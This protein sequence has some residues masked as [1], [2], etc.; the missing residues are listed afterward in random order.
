LATVH[1]KGPRVPAALLLA[2]DIAA[3]GGD[4]TGA[5]SQLDT[6]IARYPDS[7][8][9]D[10]A[11]LNR[12]ILAIRAGRGTSVLGELTGL[13]R[14]APLSPY[15]GRMRLAHGVILSTSSQAPEA[16][17]DFKTA[18]MQGEGAV[19]NLGLGRIAFERSQWDAAEREF[20][21]ARDT[22]TGAVAVAAEYGIAAILWNQGK[23][24]EFK[25]FAQTLLAKP[26]DPTM[27]PALLAASASLAAEEGRWKDAQALST[28]VATEFPKSDAAPA[29]LADVGTAAAR[30][31][32]WPLANETFKTLVDKYPSYKKSTDT[33]LDYAEAL[34]RTGAYAEAKTKLTEFIDASP[35]DPELPRALL[36]L[37]R[38][39]EALGDGAGAAEQYKRVERD[40]PAQ[41][42]AAQL[43]SARVLLLAGNWD[44]ARPI[45]E[46][47]M[48]NGDPD[49]ASEAAFRLGE[50]H[51]AAGR[52]LPAVEAYMTAV[53][54]APD[55]PMARRAL[56]GAGQSF[57]ALKQNDSAVIV[58]KKL[59]ASKSVEPELADAAKKNL[60]ALGVN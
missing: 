26:A 2:A 24:D 42:M 48:A 50:G 37:G 15:M 23:T 13:I 17:R 7:E 40:F 54:I 32:E 30:A 59:L 51:R 19:A 20:V 6:L 53:Y 49:L 33:R 3:R 4:L 52:H 47:V 56:L 14:N 16:E 28:R 18:L 38:T 60:K 43:G 45:L 55:L 44:E 34:V 10:L 12:A 31:N 41:Q 35:R 21:E 46:R 27:T 9:A 36:L 1:P 11:R 8:Y 29:A 58:Y 25:P 39:Q 5:K 57:R 22:G